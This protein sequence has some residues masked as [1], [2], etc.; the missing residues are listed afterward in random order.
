[1][2]ENGL[3]KFRTI[4]TELSSFVCVSLNLLDIGYLLPCELKVFFPD[5]YERII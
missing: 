4:V 3:I 2:Q 1:M 5:V